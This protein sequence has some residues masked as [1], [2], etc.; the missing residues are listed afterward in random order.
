MRWRDF[1]TLL[2][3]AAVAWP[4]AAEA[5][6]P[7]MSVIGYLNAGSATGAASDLKAFRQG[8]DEAGYV[9]GRNVA[10]DYR[11]ADGQMDRLPVLAADLVHRQVMVIAAGNVFAAR[12][13]KAASAT[14]PVVFS[15]AGDPIRDGLVASLNRPA[16]NVTGVATLSGELLPKKLELLHEVFPMASAVAVL[17]HPTAANAGSAPKDLQAAALA[18]GLQLRVVH[19]SSD[20]RL[21]QS[22]RRSDSNGPPR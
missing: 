17:V 11:W 22:S 16:G 1:V 20:G 5:Q 19:A 21:T 2:G 8:L 9:E 18:M 13:A 10:F 3:G 12:A 14:I 6:Q 15:T 7:G 4:L